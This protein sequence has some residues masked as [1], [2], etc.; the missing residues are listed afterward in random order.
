MYDKLCDALNGK[1]SNHLLPFLWMKDG[2]HD[3]LVSYVHQVY[4]SGCRAFCVESR[5]HE[6]FCGDE[7]WDDMAL[8]LSE[9][10]KLGMKVWILDDKHFPTGYANGLVSKYPDKR[11][12]MLVEDH[13]DVVGPAPE[14]AILLPTVCKEGEDEL[15][16]VYAYERKGM[17]ETLDGAPIDLTDRVDGQYVYWDIPQGVYRVFALYK[18][19]RGGKKDYI[20][21]IDPASVGVLIE[22]VYEPHYEHFKR[23][24]GSTLEGFFSDEPSFGNG[25]FTSSVPRGSYD[26]A[27]G[28]PG[29]ALP[30]TD[31]VLKRMNAGGGDF[32][33]LLPALW[34]PMGDT[35][36]QVRVSYMDAVTNLW[37]EAFSY[38]LG[39]WCRARGVRYIGHVIEDENAHMRLSVSGGH[40]FRSLDGQDMAGIDVVLHQVIPGLAHYTHASIAG[41]GYYSSEFFDYC[42]ARLAASHSRIQPRMNGRAMCEIFGAYGWA[43]GV[44]FMKCLM[45][46]MLVR[47]I[48][49]FVPHAFSLIFPDPD[50]PPHFNAEHFNPE[51]DAFRKLMLY[52]NKVTHLFGGSR[53]TVSAAVYYNAEAEWSGGE[54]MLIQK[55][56]RLLYD[57]QLNYDFLPMD[58][59]MND[60]SVTDG[61]LT[62]NGNAYACLVVP[63]SQYL[64]KKLLDRFSALMDAG[65]KIVFVN[66][67]PD[68]Y[69]RGDIAVLEDIP[70]YV[71][72]C[73]GTDIL[74]DKPF[75]LLRF[76]HRVRGNTHIFQF[77]NESQTDD[78]LGTVTL[79]VSGEGTQVDFLRDSVCK[80]TA[81]GSKLRL[82]LRRGESTIL[83]FDGEKV[84]LPGD[85]MWQNTR[86]LDGAWTL[87]LKHAMKDE[88]F[89][90][91]KPVA[92][93][94][95]VAGREGDSSFSGFMRYETEFVSDGNTA[96]ID[97]GVVGECA[98]LWLNGV[99]LGLRIAPPY[100]Y[101]LRGALKPGVNCLTVEVV[102]NL[103]H[104]K[105]DRFSSFLQITPSGLIG[106]VKLLE[107]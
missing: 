32:L 105:P 102:N 104:V 35:T 53:E 99:D 27:L 78:F 2:Y 95:N 21:M 52:T 33:P 31:E 20:H 38:G 94:Y 85:I 79:P 39:E 29:L 6:K 49:E 97:L 15:L 50:C 5:T 4:D 34:Y 8:I 3:K 86:E 51:F 9:A 62:V 81:D 46:H 12:L 56:A 72:A 73:G 74:L 101:D 25:T 43:E 65:A 89:T 96:G 92:R 69:D 93:L 88:G 24:F 68:G 10:E 42:L 45:D 16:G 66:A 19:R 58:S 54:R 1:E 14:S 67:R 22:A 18:S 103:V 63:Y 75:E 17:D 44:P 13:L 107:N 106:P 61:R 57:S 41:Y 26:R 80:V 48:N 37:K 77:V 7:W 71:R 55:P 87:S 36:A 11:Q 82:G 59:M 76:C 83:V 100:V 91:P 90:E 30:W 28:Q 84:D 98:H 23:Y 60:A 40:Y 70:A 47:G 64:P